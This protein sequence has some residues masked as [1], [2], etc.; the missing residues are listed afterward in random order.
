MNV[1]IV[2]LKEY[3]ITL[4]AFVKKVILINMEK[5]IVKVI[6]NLFLECHD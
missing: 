2:I 4:N 3:F 5:K 6:N 1:I